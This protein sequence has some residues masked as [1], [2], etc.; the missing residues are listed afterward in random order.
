MAKHTATIP[1]LAGIGIL[2]IVELT[3]QNIRGAVRNFVDLTNPDTLQYALFNNTGD[4]AD[5]YMISFFTHAI[6]CSV[7][8]RVPEKL[9]VGISMAI[10]CGATVATEVFIPQSLGGDLRDIPM[11]ITGAFFYL[12]LN[13]IGN[14]SRGHNLYSNPIAS[15]VTVTRS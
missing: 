15:G 3:R 4:F 14:R 1:E 9:R 6:L 10:A 12:G 8:G 5:S 7:A 11:G 13:V 2:P